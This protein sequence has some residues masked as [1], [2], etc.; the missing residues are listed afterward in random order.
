MSIIMTVEEKHEIQ[1]RYHYL[2]N[3]GEDPDAPIDPLTYVDSNGDHLL[4]IA[5]RQGDLRTVE[6]LIKAGQD[7]NQRGDMGCTALHYAL[8]SGK[9][10]VAEFLL[11]N[12]ADES[13]KNDFGR[14]ARE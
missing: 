11:L 3:F 13:V 14:V 4:H 2:V 7:V 8:M 5:T 6:L 9:A 10:D 12:G 1:G